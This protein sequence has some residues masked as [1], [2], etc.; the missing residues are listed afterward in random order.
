MK[1]RLTQFLKPTLDDYINVA[2][3]TAE[4]LERFE[5]LEGDTIHYPATTEG[6]FS[7]PDTPLVSDTSF[8]GGAAGDA[9]FYLHLYLIDKDEKWLSK[10]K[11]LLNYCISKYQGEQTYLPKENEPY[12]ET[13]NGFLAGPAGGAYVA[14]LYC[15]VSA[16]KKYMDY[17]YKVASDLK[18]AF[19]K[20]EEGLAITGSYAVLEEG[21]LIN[22]LLYAYNETGDREYL[23]I[24]CGFADYIVSKAEPVGKDGVRFYAFDSEGNGYGGRGYFPGYFHGTAGSACLLLKV[25]QYTMKD[26]YL[27]TARKAANYILDISEVSE[28]GESMWIPYLDPLVDD[29]FYLGQCQGSAG[30]SKLFYQLYDVTCDKKYLEYVIK[31]TDGI[32]ATGAPKLHSRGY[33]HVLNYCCGAAGMLEHFLHVYQLTNNEKYLQACEDCAEV[34]IRESNNEGDGRRWYTVTNRHLPGEILVLSGL[35]NGGPGIAAALLKLYNFKKD[36]N[37]L[38]RYIDDPFLD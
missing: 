22:F 34:L 33:W 36:K 2:Y 25:Y 28:D 23:D 18:R 16:E 12:P 10:G 21:G 1:M 38:P 31:L 17:F 6:V 30:T 24:A 14:H 37:I 26:S 7:Y 13:K 27:E 9:F 4:Y 15:K 8:F 3:Q 35:Y 11:A 19:K 29:L 5:I 20:Q 32:L